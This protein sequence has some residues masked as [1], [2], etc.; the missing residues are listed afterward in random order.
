VN[1]SNALGDRHRFEGGEEV[2]GEGEAPRAAGASRPEDPL[3]QLAD[4]DH[5]DRPFLVRCD[6]VDRNRPPL[7]RDED[8]GID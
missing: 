6:R 8:V 7:A 3:E 2:L 1:P 5:T 4:G